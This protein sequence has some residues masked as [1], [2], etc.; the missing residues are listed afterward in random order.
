[1]KNFLEQFKSDLAI[2]GN[3][4]ALKWNITIACVKFVFAA[5]VNLLITENA[6]VKEVLKLRR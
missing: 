6:L 5:F 3:I 4:L 2:L 1:M